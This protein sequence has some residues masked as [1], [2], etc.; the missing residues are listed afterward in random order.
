MR[1]DRLERIGLLVGG[2]LSAYFFTLVAY[3]YP[4]FDF[5]ALV[6]ALATLVFAIENLLIEFREVKKAFEVLV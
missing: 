2:C 4:I 6:I 3:D 1:K 5:L